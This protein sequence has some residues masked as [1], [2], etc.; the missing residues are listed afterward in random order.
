MASAL[1][2]SLTAEGVETSEQ[3]DFLAK[4]FCHQAQGYLYSPALREPEFAQFLLSAQN[5]TMV[6]H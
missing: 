3:E 2:I 6:T 5:T 4:S 1:N